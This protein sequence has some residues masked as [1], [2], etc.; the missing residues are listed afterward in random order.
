MRVKKKVKSVLAL[1]LC[2]ILMLTM[3]CAKGTEKEQA[4]GTASGE[5]LAEM[6]DIPADGI[7]TKDQFQ[8]VAGKD[9]KVQFKGT[10]EDGITYIWTYD[11]A[12]IQ[13][14]EDQ[15]LKIDF[16]QENLDEIKKQANDANDALQMT[17][18]GKGLI[19][20][21]TLEVTLPQSWESNAA[22]LVKEQDGKLAKMSDV[23]VTNDKDS[24]TLVMTVT[25][26]DGDCYVIGGVTEEQNKGA[27]AAN[28]SSKKKAD[29]EQDQE[30]QAGTES[31]TDAADA[32]ENAAD[33]NMQDPAGENDNAGQDAD[34]DNSQ[35][36]N[37]QKTDSKD[38]DN[39]AADQEDTTSAS[40]TC[41]ISISCA[42]VLD[43]MDNLK[44][45]KAEF[46]P[47]DGWILA[48]T[49]VEFTEG[50][51]VHDVLQRVCREAG[52]QMESSFTP[53]Y[54]SAYVEGINNL[55]EFD[56]GELSGWMFSVNGWY[57]NY[58]CSKY[59]VNAGD[60]ICWVYTCNL[61]KDVGDNSMY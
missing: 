8:S 2:A 40:N 13:N 34:T 3:G 45:S 14:P 6:N 19:C 7:I 24:T 16:T 5:A 60:E 42:T 36:E 54:N 25:S 1:F 47:S 11:C 28:Q 12:K 29:K 53:A 55:Y 22:Y 39:A 46:V 41:T 48:P 58:G 32:Q 30:T 9:Q 21:P 56:C 57:P 4:A 51:S 37:N 33:E 35:K 43:N 61:G 50:E 31:S 59:T 44:S 23:T 15:N 17:M 49:E 10:T 18:H 27:D 38:Q 26:L 20:V 52:I